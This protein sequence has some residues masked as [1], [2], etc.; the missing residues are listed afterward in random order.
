MADFII[1]PATNTTVGFDPFRADFSSATI[2]S[3]SPTT[4]VASSGGYRISIFGSFTYNAFGG[5]T[6]GYV[7]GTTIALNGAPLI[8]FNG[9]NVDVYDFVFSSSQQVEA[10]MLSGNDRLISAWNTGSIYNTYSGNDRIKL[11]TGNDVVDGGTGTDTFVVDVKFA[12]ATISLSGSSIKVDSA[13]GNDTLRN[14][15]ILKFLDTSYAVQA[16]TFSSNTLTGDQVS[17]L[18]RD[19]IFG[20]FGHDIISGKSGNDRLFGDGDN[21]VINGGR[22]SDLVNGGTGN[23]TLRGASGKDWIFGASGDDSVNGGTGDD[24]LFGQIGKDNIN[25]GAGNDALSG[26]TGRDILIGHLGNDTLTGGAQA[27]RFVFHKGHGQ[28][29]ITD[30]EIGV[31]KIEIGRGASRLNQLTFAKKGDDV[32]VSFADVEVMVND[33]T[34]KQLNDGDNFVF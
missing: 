3:S 2:L 16:G 25:G 13:F 9:F 28:N 18:P 19:L 24:Q 31:D 30:F 1:H 32:K 15:E 20:G 21:D 4:I 29:V 22:G 27:D 5:L 6:G 17:S 23:D 10:A 12:S 7:T 14:I 26:G 33:V 34:V 11:G 8:D